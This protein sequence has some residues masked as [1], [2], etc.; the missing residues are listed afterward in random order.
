VRDPAGGIAFASDDRVL[1][2]TFIVRGGADAMLIGGYSGQAPTPTPRQL[3]EL[4]HSRQLRFVILVPSGVRA[5]QRGNRAR[6]NVRAWVEAHC[7]V[8]EKRAFVGTSPQLDT[9]FGCHPNA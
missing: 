5:V 9:L 2:E 3:R 4:V 1:T 6:D 7:D 8:V